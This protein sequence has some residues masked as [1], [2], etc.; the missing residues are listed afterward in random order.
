M[1]LKI[2]S[3]T[4]EMESQQKAMHAYHVHLH[5][6]QYRICL[7]IIIILPAALFRAATAWQRYIRCGIMITNFLGSR[8]LRFGLFHDDANYD[9][10]LL[11][12]SALFG[13]IWAAEFRTPTALRKP[14]R[15]I[16]REAAFYQ[17]SHVQ[18]EMTN[19][20]EEVKCI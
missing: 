2:H 15:K 10:Q 1:L 18:H 6:G 13:P 19:T 17:I 8:C 16:I 20:S 12:N 5:H 4:F 3:S 14:Y 11:E 7:R 9:V